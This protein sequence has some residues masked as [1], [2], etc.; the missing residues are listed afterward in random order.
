MVSPR[1]H[2]PPASPVAT[3]QRL[4]GPLSQ[5]A[6]I[7][8]TVAE[9]PAAPAAVDALVDAQADALG[10]L[11]PPGQSAREQSGYAMHHVVCH[12][13]CWLDV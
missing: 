4:I 8:P 3:R 9:E 5:A 2:T 10:G 12:A 7:V 11:W 6:N 13:A 1:R